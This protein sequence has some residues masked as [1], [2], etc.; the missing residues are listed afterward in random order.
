MTKQIFISVVFVLTLF[1]CGNKSSK[2]DNKFNESSHLSHLASKQFA[3]T[4]GNLSSDSNATNGSI[5]AT[6]KMQRSRAAHTAGI[7]AGIVLTIC[8]FLLD[9]KFVTEYRQFE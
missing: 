2:P 5:I 7:I 9:K 1:T 6:A 3:D 4:L 8:I